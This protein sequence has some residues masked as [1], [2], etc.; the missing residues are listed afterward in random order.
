MKILVFCPMKGA[1]VGGIATYYHQ[2]LLPL[3]TNDPRITEVANLY[4]EDLGYTPRIDRVRNI[5]STRED[6]S[7]D[8]TTLR[9]INRF[10]V[11]HIVEFVAYHDKNDPKNY[12]LWQSLLNIEIPIVVTI[13]SDIGSLSRGTKDP[14]QFG[15]NSFLTHP[16][17]EHVIAYRPRY[18]DSLFTKYLD[19]YKV[20]LALADRDH[21]YSI[22]VPYLSHV[23][24]TG[25]DDWEVRPNSIGYLGRYGG[26]KRGKVLLQSYLSGKCSRYDSVLM[27]T[28]AR[29]N[30]YWDTMDLNSKIAEI[31]NQK[32]FLKTPFIFKG[33]FGAEDI[34]E[35]CEQVRY[36]V[37]P[38]DLVDLGFPNEWMY[39]ECI[40]YGVIPIVSTK[41]N[42]DL[43]EELSFLKLFEHEPT[44]QVVDYNKYIELGTEEMSRKLIDYAKK[45]FLSSKEPSDELIRI[46]HK[47]TD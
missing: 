20:E 38:S 19:K 44:T 37:F 39:Q 5:R 13:Q 31:N 4:F 6:F 11:L 34:K 26:V 21:N 8:S 27:A 1:E 29:N 12:T 32:D 40:S 24:P 17:L 33:S 7:S 28:D 15:S 30:S 3:L 25:V 46:Y 18:L 45:H 22:H 35:L 47:V 36:V 2:Y 9:D 43:P 42:R 16:M 41:F 10:D 14:Y 23:D